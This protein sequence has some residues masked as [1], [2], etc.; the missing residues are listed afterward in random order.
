MESKW[1]VRKG[2]QDQCQ[3]MEGKQ[4]ARVVQHKDSSEENHIMMDTTVH[5]VMYSKERKNS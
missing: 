3:E 4:C 2:H 5:T 1:G